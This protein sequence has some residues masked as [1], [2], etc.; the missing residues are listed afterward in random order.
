MLS[1]RD[2]TDAIAETRITTCYW[3]VGQR[4]HILTQVKK[5]NEGRGKHGRFLLGHEVVDSFCGGVFIVDV[6]SAQP[7]SGIRCGLC[8]P[9]G[10]GG[11]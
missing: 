6:S 3:V 10:L 4:A 1:P 9:S 2:A 11:D 5:L 8:G 7:F